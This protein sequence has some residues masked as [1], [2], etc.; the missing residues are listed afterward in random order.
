MHIYIALIHEMFSL[1]TKNICVRVRRIKSRRGRV[2]NER[3][4]FHG[5]VP[6]KY[7]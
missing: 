6:R 5:D 2:Q 7:I 4:D 3:N 1:F